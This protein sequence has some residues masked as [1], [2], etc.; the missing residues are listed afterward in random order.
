MN[1]KM[2]AGTQHN[3]T[4]DDAT[5]TTNLPDSETIISMLELANMFLHSSYWFLMLSIYLARLD[6]SGLAWAAKQK[7][8]VCRESATTIFSWILGKGGRVDLADIAMPVME[9]KDPSAEYMVAKWDQLDKW[10]ET[11]MEKI[12]ATF[13]G[14]DNTGLEEI[15]RDLLETFR[16]GYVV[17]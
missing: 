10:M 11:K 12:M 8:I 1:D 7:D 4:K 16:K 13:G 2:N 14:G 6:L 15:L 3:D 9:E 5:Q 17:N